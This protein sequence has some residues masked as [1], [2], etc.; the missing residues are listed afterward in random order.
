MLHIP[1][2]NLFQLQHLLQVLSLASPILL[3]QH[4]LNIPLDS[5]GNVVHVLGLDDGMQVVLQYPGE[6]VLQ[7][8]APEVGKDFLPVWCVLRHNFLLSRPDSVV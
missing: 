7:L 5:L 2:Q 8:A 3:Y 4:L 6:V 1:I